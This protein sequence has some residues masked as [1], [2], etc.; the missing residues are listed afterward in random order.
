MEQ[1]QQ[2]FCMQCG[3]SLSATATFCP[4]CGAD[5]NQPRVNMPSPTTSEPIPAGIRGW[6]WGAFWLTWLWAIFN[7]TWIGLLALIPL[8]NLG[9]MVVLG[10]KG[11]EW[12]WR[13]Q[14]WSSVDEFNRV[15]KKWNSASWII[16]AAGL[17]LGGAA[18]YMDGHMASQGRWNASDSDTSATDAELGLDLPPPKTATAPTNNTPYPQPQLAFSKIDFLRA[19][20][21]IGLD[22]DQK[23]ELTNYL[24]NPQVFWSECVARDSG[25]AQALGGANQTEAQAHGVASCQATAKIYYQCLHNTR[26]DDAAMCLQ[27]YISNIAGD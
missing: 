6:S 10:L 11:R 24:S 14:R 4:H 27:Q 22:D 2:V 25:M 18:I 3:E 17:V 12:A 21:E 19:L 15:Q 16:V 9:M 7:K 8:V 23:K 26:L 13:N 1:A 5:Q 20:K